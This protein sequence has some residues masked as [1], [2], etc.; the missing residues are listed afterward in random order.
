[1]SWSTSTKSNSSK[2][3]H[4]YK[5]KQTKYDKK[6]EINLKG[7]TKYIPLVPKDALYR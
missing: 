2:N 5:D 6:C 3:S 1:M 7:K 4:K